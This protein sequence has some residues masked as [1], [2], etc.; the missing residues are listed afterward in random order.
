M[1]PNYFVDTAGGTSSI[2]YEAKYKASHGSNSGNEM[3]FNHAGGCSTLTLTEIK[4]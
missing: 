1:T 4:V 2:T 3:K